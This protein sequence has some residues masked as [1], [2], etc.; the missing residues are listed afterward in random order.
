MGH[1]DCKSCGQLDCVCPRT[2]IIE[3]AAKRCIR[4]TINTEKLEVKPI[5]LEVWAEDPS[6]YYLPGNTTRFMRMVTGGFFETEKLARAALKKYCKD[7]IK[8]LQ[9]T[10]K[11]LS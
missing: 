7:R 8:E 2:K 4:W 10:I 5:E 11:S 6:T 1:Y 9:A 3:R